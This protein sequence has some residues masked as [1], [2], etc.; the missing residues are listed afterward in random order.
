VTWWP[1][2]E[3]FNVPIQPLSIGAVA[4]DFNLRGV[5]TKPEVKRLDVRL[6]DWRGQQNVVLAFHNYAFTAT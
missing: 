6:S 3:F 4:P 1:G 5:I 2:S